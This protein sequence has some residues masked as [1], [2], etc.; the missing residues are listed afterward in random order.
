MTK[1]FS[2]E[3]KDPPE[4]IT[5]ASA[6]NFAVQVRAETL[7]HAREEHERLPEQP[8]EREGGE[9][10]AMSKSCSVAVYLTNAIVPARMGT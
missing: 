9:M 2:G 5:I 7:E 3:T 1:V 8:E 10:V 4:A 6:Q